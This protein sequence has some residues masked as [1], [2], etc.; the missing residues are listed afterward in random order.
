MPVWDGNI[1]DITDFA[2]NKYLQI[3]S[4]GFQNKLPDH[5][6]IRKKGRSDYHILLINSGMCEVLHKDKLYTLTAG[7][8]VI[9]APG[10]E[11]KYTFKSEGTSLWCHFTGK[12]VEEL[13]N[14]C[15]ISSG[16]YFLNPS[17]TIFE[18]YSDLIQRFHQPGREQ[19]AN[20]SL[21]ELIYS[22]CDAVNCS[23]KK[24]NSDLISPILTYINANYNKQITL[25]KL[26]EKSGYSKS[27]F[28][29][30][31]S[32]ITGTTPIKY[33]NDI[34]LKVSCELLQSTEL[35]VA[36][37]AFRCGFN[38]PLYYSK[39][40]KKKYNLTPTEYRSSI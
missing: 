16:V 22:I 23:D 6:I 30:I 4:C 31:F 38:D 36:D 27:R 24:E 2:A 5:A 17:K 40:F 29:H 33:Q 8:L 19:Y 34:R 14:S 1:N 18:S 12:I 26:A 28:S 39:I 13:L 15:C 25:D 21:L 9:Y 11:Q 3:N 7:N 37:I 10:E 20:A 35:T 32:E